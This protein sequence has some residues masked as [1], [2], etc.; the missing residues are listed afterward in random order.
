MRFGVGG[1]EAHTLKEVGQKFSVTEEQIQQ[2][3]AKALRKLRKADSP[4]FVWAKND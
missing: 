4:A 1:G 2:V 3:E